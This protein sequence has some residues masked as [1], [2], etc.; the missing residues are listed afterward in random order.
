MLAAENG[1]RGELENEGLSLVWIVKGEKRVLTGDPAGNQLG[2]S[3]IRAAYSL[4]ADGEFVG[5]AT[6]DF[7]SWD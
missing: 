3:Q 7:H 1:I 5:E 2:K 4:N 6:S